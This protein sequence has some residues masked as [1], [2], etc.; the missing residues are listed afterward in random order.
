MIQVGLLRFLFG[1]LP[2]NKHIVTAPLVLPIRPHIGRLESDNLLSYYGSDDAGQM[3]SPSSSDPPKLHG[4]DFTYNSVFSSAS[5]YSLDSA[6]GETT[7]KYNLPVKEGT[8]PSRRL[9]ERSEGGTDRR[10]LAVVQ[11]NSSDTDLPKPADH[12]RGYA[13]DFT[14]PRSLRSRRGFGDRLGDIAL[15]AP[16]DASP[17]AYTYLTPPSTAPASGNRTTQS[18]SVTQSGHQRSLSEIGSNEPIGH[19]RKTSSRDVGIVGFISANDLSNKSV[20]PQTYIKTDSLSSPIFQ[21]PQVHSAYSPECE[22]APHRPFQ[23]LDSAVAAEPPILTPEIGQEKDLNIG[24]AA[25]IVV[26]L[27]SVKIEPL[28]TRKTSTRASALASRAQQ[29][30]SPPFSP[31]NPPP[32]INQPHGNLMVFRSLTFF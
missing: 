11:M 2:L 25:P 10:R 12:G 13:S 6:P 21:Q 16:P 4:K 8:E 17:R 15:V 14:P 32:D 24:V 7:V 29:T 30:P 27:T 26:N 20:K 5:D 18:A 9:G 28:V 23:H 1:A 22:D 3:Y 19:H 31:P